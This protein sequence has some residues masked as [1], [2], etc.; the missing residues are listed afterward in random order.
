MYLVHG[1]ELTA[2]LER[3]FERSFM[4]VVEHSASVAKVDTGNLDG[5]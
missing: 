2:T 4:A 5:C 3:I 1:T